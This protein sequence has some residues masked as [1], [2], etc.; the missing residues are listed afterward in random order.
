MEP[1]RHYSVPAVAAL[2]R[3]LCAR[4]GLM[5]TLGNLAGAGLVIVLVL[6]LEWRLRP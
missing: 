2:V 6:W 5:D 3:E 1:L 4:G